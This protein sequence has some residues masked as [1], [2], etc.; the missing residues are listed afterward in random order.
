MQAALKFLP[1][2]IGWFSLNVPSGL[3]LYWIINNI[4]ST[5]TS[6]LIR[7]QLGVPSP[8]LG[9]T[10]GTATLLSPES[11]TRQDPDVARANGSSGGGDGEGGAQ[12]EEARGFGGTAEKEV[13][14]DIIAANAR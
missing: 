1:L 14:G 13:E 8:A 9:A 7:Q 4:V 2:L 12:L 3:G 5:A 10:D 11:G 6:V